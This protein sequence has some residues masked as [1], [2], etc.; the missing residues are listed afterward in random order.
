MERILRK[1]NFEHYS[2]LINLVFS[3]KI[4]TI[5]CINHYYLNL[6][7]TNSRYQED[8]EK[9]DLIFPDGIGMKLALMV[10]FNK[11]LRDVPYL[12]GS[13]FYLKVLEKVNKERGKIFLFGDKT[14][15]LLKAKNFINDKYDGIKIVGYIDGYR[16]INNR[17]II[18]SINKEPIS[19][20][21]VGIGPIK[22]EHWVIENRD[23]IKAGKIIIVGGWFRI[24]AM[25][26]KRGPLWIRKAGLEWFVRLMTEPQKVWKRYLLGIPV[27]FVRII[28]L[29]LKML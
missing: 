21:F 6:L 16:N 28:I 23:L 2:K 15:I 9:F 18:E 7:Y 4:K 24:L 10:L 5:T 19:I 13:D 22:Q 11:S 14:D 1:I 3:E 8:V 27:F 17:E 12:T 25:D 26:R 20:L 29:K